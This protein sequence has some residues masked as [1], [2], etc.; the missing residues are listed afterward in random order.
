MPSPD[1]I[2]S[3]ARTFFNRQSYLQPRG[4]I[5]ASPVKARLV[6]SPE[7]NETAVAKAS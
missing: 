6:D 3:S 4:Y 2:V 5:A 7:E 1:K